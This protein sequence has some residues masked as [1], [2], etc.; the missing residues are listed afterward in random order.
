MTPPHDRHDPPEN[1]PFLFFATA[2]KGT[3][4]AIRDELREHRFR[5]VRA[6]RGGVHFRGALSEGFR[7]C[8][9]L[10]TA[11]RVLLLLAEFE[12]PDGE[13]LYEGIYS[14]DWS[15]VLDEKRTLA[16]RAF[17]KE[18]ALGH[19]Q[20]IA[21]KT[22][23]AVVD[24]L[25]DRTGN[26]PDVDRDDPDVVLFV[27]LA[28]DRASVYLDLSG[29]ALH[30]RGYRQQSVEAPLKE[31][32]AACLLRMS[33]WDRERPLVDPMCGSGTFAIEAALWSRNV[34]PGLSRERFGFE[35]WRS[36]GDEEA[37]IMKDLREAARARIVKKGP[38]IWG[39]DAERSA[40]DAARA[41]ARAAGVDVRIDQ[42]IIETL[43]PFATPG[44]VIVNP[45]YGERLPGDAPLYEA[46][47]AAFRRMS[48]HRVAILA[49][50]LAAEHALPRKPVKWWIVYNGAIECRFLVTDIP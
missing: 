29:D 4:P 3:E 11:V 38:P 44:H 7:A 26:R 6:D 33:E 23:D 27:H 22:K 17:S 40:V 45:P 41:N 15:L 25:R 35:R 30:K 49:G 13:A 34:A 20:F 28:H 14:I 19:T 24:Q 31:S 46:M 32:L 48:G 9:L 36:F 1:E 21:Q 2:A 50:S 5:G 43:E 37:R 47:A 12:A 10:R 16:V 8:L 42:R 39:F 18:S